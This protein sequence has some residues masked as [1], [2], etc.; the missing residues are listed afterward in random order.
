M[1]LIENFADYQREH[2]AD[3]AAEAALA[4]RAYEDFDDGRQIGFESAERPWSFPWLNALGEHISA[5]C[6]LDAQTL[7]RVLG[8]GLVRR[9]GY[10]WGAMEM[11]T[12]QF[13]V[14]QPDGVHFSPS[15]TLGTEALEG[16]S[17]PHLGVHLVH[18]PGDLEGPQLFPDLG[19]PGPEGYTSPGQMTVGMYRSL[20]F[21]RALTRSLDEPGTRL[22]EVASLAALDV[23]E[24]DADLA[25][26][27]Y[28][29]AIELGMEPIEEDLN[30][31]LGEHG[32]IP[33]I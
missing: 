10:V 17:N 6:P 23:A 1:S 20:L 19:T 5:G 22:T 25:V 9:Y 11:D 24:S 32:R 4:A 33:L 21:H 7:G 27:L 16:W 13:G 2:S 31:T 26:E 3:I 15:R 30:R 18:I 29:R 28:N 8:E 12:R 14:F